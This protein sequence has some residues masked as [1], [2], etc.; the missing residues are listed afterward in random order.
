MTSQLNPAWQRKAVS[1]DHLAEVSPRFLSGGPRPEQT[2]DGCQV[3]PFLLDNPQQEWIP[4]DLCQLLTQR[5][6]HSL[7]NELPAEAGHAP[8]VALATTLAQQPAGKELCLLTTLSP[9]IMHACRF[10]HV[11][12]LVPANLDAVLTA[13]QRIKLLATPV[14]PDIGIIVEGPRDQHAAWRYFRKLAVGSLRYLDIPLLNLGFLPNR[15]TAQ[16]DPADRQ[17]DNFLGRIGERL[18]RSEFHCRYRRNATTPATRQ[19]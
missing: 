3:I 13:Y 4:R 17:R 7:L 18:L 5:G 19:K 16:T 6:H 14:A 12:L 1:S 9:A 8:E 11:V 15:V 2:S 10:D